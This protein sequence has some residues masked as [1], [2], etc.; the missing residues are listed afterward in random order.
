MEKVYK[1]KTSNIILISVLKTAVIYILATI[2][3]SI[4]D[5]FI[6]FNFI[7]R[8]GYFVYLMG[9]WTI[10]RILLAL[11]VFT[12]ILFED[13]KRKM[14]LITVKDREINIKKNN[15]EEFYNFS[16]H[17]FVFDQTETDLYG[18]PIWVN[19]LLKII[20]SHGD[21]T[22]IKCYAFD[23]KTIND[24]KEEVKKGES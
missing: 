17:K 4:L 11:I 12:A 21:V 9:G 8:F 16:N 24:L 3:F 19:Y 14:V 20:D 23:K 7:Y 1:A 18:H 5:L 2:I 6:N 13:Y 15:L 22:E 10:I